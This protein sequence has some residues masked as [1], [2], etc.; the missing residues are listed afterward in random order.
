M[1]SGLFSGKKGKAVKPD[2]SPN[3]SAWESQN[4]SDHG[5]RKQQKKKPAAAQGWADEWHDIDNP[6]FF[7][8]LRKFSLHP[9]NHGS[10]HQERMRGTDDARPKPHLL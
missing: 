10:P 4:E 6:H 8:E 2:P 3:S 1:S 7:D 5:Q 9:F